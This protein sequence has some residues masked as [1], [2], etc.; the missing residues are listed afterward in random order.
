MIEYTSKRYVDGKVRT[1]IVDKDGKIINRNPRKDELQ[2]LKEET[3]VRNKV[4][5]KYNETNTCDRCGEKLKVEQTNKIRRERDIEGI[6]TGKWLC[7][8]CKSQIV[9]KI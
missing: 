9:I 6:E 1:V 7:I 5:K 4:S 3:Y 2:N 8:K